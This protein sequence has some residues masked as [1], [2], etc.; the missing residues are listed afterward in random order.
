MGIKFTSEGFRT[1]VVSCM[2]GEA[3]EH[4]TE[5]REGSLLQLADRVSKR[6]MALCEERGVEMNDE[7]YNEVVADLAPQFSDSNG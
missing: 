6:C 4:Y 5:F 7:I 1:L 2:T 3:G